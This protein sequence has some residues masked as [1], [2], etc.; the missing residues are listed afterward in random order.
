MI[1][2]CISGAAVTERNRFSVGPQRTLPPIWSATKRQDSCLN[3]VPNW[4]FC[5]AKTLPVAD[6]QRPVD[7]IKLTAPTTMARSAPVTA[8]NAYVRLR[9]R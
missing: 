8:D 7:A 1:T 6:R 3:H 5:A 2:E 4:P 9:M